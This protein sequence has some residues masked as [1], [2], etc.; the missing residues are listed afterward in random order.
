MNINKIILSISSIFSN[1]TTVFVHFN[2]ERNR[3]QASKKIEVIKYEEFNE[4]GSKIVGY[5]LL[6]WSDLGCRPDYP[7]NPL[8]RE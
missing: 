2:H 7:T 1:S 8:T 6:K 4:I 5:K 3:P